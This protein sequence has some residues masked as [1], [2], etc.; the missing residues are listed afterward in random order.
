M[1]GHPIEKSRSDWIISP[2]KG[3]KI[4]NIRCQQLDILF[5]GKKKLPHQLRLVVY[6]MICRVSYIQGGCLGFLPSTCR[7]GLA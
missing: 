6:P 7:L 4:E 3:L 2:N 1:V 5:D